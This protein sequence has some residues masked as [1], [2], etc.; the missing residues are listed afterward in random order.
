MPSTT[1]NMPPLHCSCTEPAQGFSF[2]EEIW[3]RTVKD[4]LRPPKKEPQTQQEAATGD[5]STAD[6]N[7]DQNHPLPNFIDLIT[8]RRHR[9]P[10]WLHRLR[11]GRDSQE[12]ALSVRLANVQQMQLRLLQGR[13]TWLALSAGFDQDYGV[14]EGVLT[15]LGPTL[16]DY[17]GFASYLKTPTSI[18][19]EV[20]TREEQ[21]GNT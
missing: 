21:W 8:N 6:E 17:G 15:Q 19:R 4:Y 12:Y 11:H 3:A 14:S 16:R 7:A 2:D 1:E 10:G 13:L 20:Q 9:E 5:E 18:C